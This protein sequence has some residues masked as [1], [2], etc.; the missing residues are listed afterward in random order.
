MVIQGNELDM[1]DMNKYLPFMREVI[2]NQVFDRDRGKI[3]A[4]ICCPHDFQ[5]FDGHFPGQP[6]LPAVIQLVLVRILVADLLQVPL[7]TVKTGRI[8]F[9]GMIT[10]DEKIQIQ[11]TVEEIDQCWKADFKL[12]KLEAIVASGTIM[13]NTRQE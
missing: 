2:D 12:R 4:E 3:S 10:P 11:V 7:E 6:V 1:N 13:F 8:K 9:K 5:A